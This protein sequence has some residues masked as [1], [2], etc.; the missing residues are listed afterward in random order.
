MPGTK[1]QETP[2]DIW[3]NHKA[4]K[5][6]QIC[7]WRLKELKLNTTDIMVLVSIARHCGDGQVEGWVAY[8]TLADESLCSERTAYKSVERLLD[9]GV[10]Y[11]IGTHKTGEN[12]YYLTLTQKQY[13]EGVNRMRS[14]NHTPAFVSQ[15]ADALPELNENGD[16]DWTSPPA[17]SSPPAD[18]APPAE[19]APAPSAVPPCRICT[20]GDLTEMGRTGGEPACMHASGEREAGSR[21]DGEQGNNPGQQMEGKTEIHSPAHVKGTTSPLG[22]SPI[23]PED[24]LVPARPK[25]H[26]PAK[27]DKTAAEVL[28]DSLTAK[29]VQPSQPAAPPVPATPSQDLASWYQVYLGEREWELEAS[30]TIWPGTLQPLLKQSDLP[31]IKANII[32]YDERFPAFREYFPRHRR[33]PETSAKYLVDHYNDILE[34]RDKHAIRASKRSKPQQGS[35]PANNQPKPALVEKPI[36]GLKIL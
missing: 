34:A 1:E 27:L 8:K 23:H 33:N 7:A 18:S 36:R 5:L 17:P 11:I 3:V 28:R 19:S 13:W 32:W 6:V 14:H 4:Q 20:Q 9:A 22:T 30:R 31:D 25:K 21:E 16:C 29:P 15:G 35:Y 26:T 10:I 2:K 24:N 12:V